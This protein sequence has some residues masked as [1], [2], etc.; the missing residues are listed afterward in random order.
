MSCPRYDADSC[1]DGCDEHVEEKDLEIDFDDV[2]WPEDA[3]DLMARLAEHWD[4]NCWLL[5]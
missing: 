5:M 2:D 4:E 1:P 3:N